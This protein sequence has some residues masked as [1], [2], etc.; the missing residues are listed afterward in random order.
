LIL[1]FQRVFWHIFGTPESRNGV[2]YLFHNIGLVA[3][4]YAI[5]VAAS[6]YKF[7]ADDM[8]E[9][10]SYAK[11]LSDPTLFPKDLYIQSLASNPWNERT[12]FSWILTLGN[13]FLPQWAFFLHVFFAMIMLSG[14][15]Q[16]ST[17][18]MESN[19]MRW[20]SVLAIAVFG[21]M[22]SIGGN[23]LYAPYLVP[24]L[25]AKGM[26]CWSVYFMLKK[27]WQYAFILLIPITFIQPIVGAQLLL[28]SSAGWVMS[29]SVHRKW[30]HLFWLLVPSLWLFYLYNYIVVGDTNTVQKVIGFREFI[31]F[32]MPHHFFWQFAGTKDIIICF[33]LYV[34]GLWATWRFHRP[35]F[36]FLGCISLG[37]IFYLL[38]VALDLDLALK[39]QWLKTTI[40]IE[41]LSI[42]TI[43]A[44]LQQKF[45]LK[46]PV[47]YA[48]LSFFIALLIG[49]SVDIPG[50]KNKEYLIGD[51]WEE[52]LATDIA[53]KARKMCPSDALVA[54]PI[55][56]SRFR[57]ASE[58]SVYVDFKSIAHHTAY[59]QEWYTRMQELYG[60]DKRYVAG[61][62]MLQKGMNTYLSYQT[63][64]IKAF[65]N[66]GINYWLT[67]NT[68]KLELPVIAQNA[69]YI[70]YEIPVD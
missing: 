12:F 70:L 62:N 44:F 40:W 65:K 11:W 68:Q 30:T 10:L 14:L 23:E 25:M 33:L 24:S 4:C 6:G 60:V 7:G 63:N 64:D 21:P 45:V 51:R 9:G 59:H 29:P 52:N 58:R 1:T 22:V 41:A 16:I 54:V 50:L 13:D 28:L 38:G 61:F 48:L 67:Y 8:T 26:G 18:F 34:I 57:F 55:D 43:M 47:Y 56:D 17:L 36:W 32:R 27:K 39:T 3:L 35:Y 69:M 49:I 66:K 2:Y 19:L 46:V 37:L 53:L 5:V 31:H 15:Y 42:M 20:M